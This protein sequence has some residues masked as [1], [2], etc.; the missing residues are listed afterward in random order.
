[1]SRPSENPVA[2]AISLAAEFSFEQRQE[3]LRMAHEA[4]LCV[5]DGRP[6][7]YAGPA[8]DWLLEPR[9]VFTTL[10]LKSDLKGDLRGTLDAG[11]E[12]SLRGC[13]GY[14]LPVAALGRAIIETARAAAFDDSRFSPVSRE[15]AGKLEISLSILSP[16]RPIRPADVQIGRHGLLISEGAN[17]GLLLPQVPI[18]NR[19]DRETFLEQT[20]HKAGL[21][22]DAWRQSAKV[23]AFTAEVFGDSDFET[24]PTA[25]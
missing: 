23:E 8:A 25:H 7:P 10:Y 15:E 3:M 9:G 12:H 19:W 4:I 6:L 18:E 24:P 21:P 14:A 1:M 11:R 2:N 17:R 5:A 13:V 20:C 22:A 16:L